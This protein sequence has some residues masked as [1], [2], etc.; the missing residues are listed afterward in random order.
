MSAAAPRSWRLE[1][2]EGL[3][4]AACARLDRLFARNRGSLAPEDGALD[5]WAVRRVD[6]E[7][8]PARVLRI[9]AGQDGP[10]GA[11]DARLHWPRPRT[12]CIQQIVV[13]PAL[14]HRGVGRALVAAVL[15]DVRSECD[16]VEAHLVDPGG[17]AGG[18]WWAL[19][20]DG[21]PGG[22]FAA[23]IEAVLGRIAS[24]GATDDGIRYPA[25]V[26]SIRVARPDELAACQALRHRVFVVGQA[27]PPELEVDGLDGACVHFVGTR[28]AEVVAT[29]R[30]RPLDARRAK[31]ERVC[32]VPELR[33][34]G[35]GQALMGAMEA[36]ATRRGFSTLV[37]NAQAAVVGFYRALGYRAYG[38][39]FLEAGIEH[40]AMELG[41]D[42]AGEHA[43]A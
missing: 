28:G 20:L 16:E 25:P 3:D 15:R 11:I 29:A 42:A 36:E 34:R 43:D 39:R 13:N 32:V 31:V 38:D 2:P 1:G 6:A 27:V 14:R 8:D 12:V 4:E 7:L 21:G 5:P 30:L 35:L 33:G 18:F 23:P 26:D 17:S 37:L 24:P 10:F 22:R 41:L 9:A 19:G 40:Q